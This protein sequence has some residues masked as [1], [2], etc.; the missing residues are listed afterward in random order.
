MCIRDSYHVEWFGAECDHDTRHGRFWI[1]R[2]VKRYGEPER[3]A[4]YR[5]LLLLGFVDAVELHGRDH[6]RRFAVAGEWHHADCRNRARDGTC[7]WHHVLRAGKGHER[8]RYDLRRRGSLHD[9]S[10]ANSYDDRSDR[11]FHGGRDAE[12]YG[13]PER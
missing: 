5:D 3:F 4:H 12:R 10:N 2:D 11:S 8:A 1:G 6:A 13:E 9:C 7:S